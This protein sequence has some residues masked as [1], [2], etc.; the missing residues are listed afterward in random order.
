MRGSSRSG[1]HYN[2]ALISG[3]MHQSLSALPEKP[4]CGTIS[5][6]GLKQS[7]IKEGTD[8]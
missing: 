4:F 1:H 3:A 5:G 6:S 2:D 7:V 8:V